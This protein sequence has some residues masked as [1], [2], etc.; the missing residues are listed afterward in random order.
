[1]YFDKAHFEVVKSI[2]DV[3]KDG[4]MKVIFWSN[5]ITIKSLQKF[6][7]KTKTPTLTLCP[8]L[9]VSIEMLQKGTRKGVAL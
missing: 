1:M 7:D 5:P 6:I 8:H 2:D 9:F 3:P 4:W